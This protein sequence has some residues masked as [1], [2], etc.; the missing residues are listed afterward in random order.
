[1]PQDPNDE[2]ASVLLRA[3]GIGTTQMTR[4]TRTSQTVV[5]AAHM[6]TKG[7]K[8]L[9]AQTSTTILVVL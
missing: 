8:R 1:V 3:D 2:K 6:I 9:I 5:P 7:H 4:Q